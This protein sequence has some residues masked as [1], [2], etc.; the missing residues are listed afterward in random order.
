MPEKLE[1]VISDLT[2][3]WQKVQAE[4]FA[5]ADFLEQAGHPSFHKKVQMLLISENFSGTIQALWNGG[6]VPH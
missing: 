1:P 3:I 6:N 2:A 4:L 5:F